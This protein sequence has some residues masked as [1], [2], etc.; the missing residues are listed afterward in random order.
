MCSIDPGRPIQ[1]MGILNLTPDSFYEPSRYNLPIMDSGADIID[2]G[3]CSTRPGSIPV[4][5]EE[6]WRRLEPVIWDIARHHSSL[7]ISVDTFR[8]GIVQRVHRYLP[9]FIVND[10]SGAA[11]PG[12]L[13]L[14][15]R[16]R[17][18]YIAMHGWAKH[19]APLGFPPEAQSSGQGRLA[20]R[21]NSPEPMAGCP[22]TPEEAS[23]SGQSLSRAS[24]SR[25]GDLSASEA[26]D[27]ARSEPGPDCYEQSLSRASLSRRGNLS[28]SEAQDYARS[29]PE[30]IIQEVFSYFESF[31]ER[32]RAEGIQDWYLDPG[33]GFGKSV[34]EN[35]RLLQDL[36]TLKRFGRPILVGI[37]RKRMTRE[38]YGL[39]P[40]QALEQTSRLHLT[41]LRG[42]AD[43][44][45]V[46]DVEDARKVIEQ[47]RDV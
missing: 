35:L 9:S 2:I 39:T 12:M 3:A 43:I 8:P 31:A 37:S 13:P 26:Q 16:L 44:L 18:P 7:R 32:L 14:V 45:R 22:E 40:G 6:E 24:L 28:A 27:F 29:E 21:E 30:S 38:P 4:G 47:Y 25:R 10:V 20:R 34:D 41:A 17:L 11:D 15:S 46:H 42:G 36:H 5:E 23:Y 1:V 19:I 33:F